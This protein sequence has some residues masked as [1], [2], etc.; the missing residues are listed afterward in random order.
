[1]FIAG[2]INIDGEILSSQEMYSTEDEAFSAAVD[3]A[4]DINDVLESMGEDRLL[5]PYVIQENA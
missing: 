1:M 2:A 4:E 3:Y 5:Q